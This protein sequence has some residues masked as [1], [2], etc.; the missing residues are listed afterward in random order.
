LGSKVFYTVNA[1]SYSSAISE[2]AADEAASAD[3]NANGQA[4]D[5]ANGTCGAT[6]TLNMVNNTARTSSSGPYSWNIVGARFVDVNGGELT[7]LNHKY[8]LE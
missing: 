2:A 3:I 5:N 6:L 1:G 4:Y 7:S 8:L